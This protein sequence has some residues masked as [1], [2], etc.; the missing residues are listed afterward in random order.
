M[1][2]NKK[3]VGVQNNGYFTGEPSLFI[4][5]N[6][7]DLDCSWCDKKFN[8]D[9]ETEECEEYMLAK[10]IISINNTH[11]TDSIVF[12]GGEPLLQKTSLVELTNFISNRVKI[13]LETHG[14]IEIP[15]ELLIRDSSFFSLSPKLSN[16]ETEYNKKV[17][18]RNIKM[19]N[20]RNFW[21]FQLVFNIDDVK[22]DME[23]SKEFMRRVM[24]PDNCTVI[25]QPVGNNRY[26]EGINTKLN[27]IMTYY[28]QN[29]EG[30]RYDVRFMPI[31]S[32]LDEFE[33]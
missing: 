29:N 25:F 20:E 7:C 26:V 15:E 11:Q 3:T 23:E 1:K 9:N 24:L 2:I 13:T 16:A 5:M 22:K 17:F 21:N 28:F 6:E 30:M 14:G 4:H 31:L 27:E 10:D 33:R 19:F 8:D 12:T 32:D 18:E